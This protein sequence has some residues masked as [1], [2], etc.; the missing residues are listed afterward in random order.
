MGCLL[1]LLFCREER[2]RL[3]LREEPRRGEGSLRARENRLV[4]EICRIRR[5]GGDALGAG[6]RARCIV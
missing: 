1:L 2:Q 6:S 5:C 4:S 3:L